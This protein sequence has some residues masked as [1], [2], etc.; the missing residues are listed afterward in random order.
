M[1]VV[2][3]SV[4][5]SIIVKDEFY[6]NAREFLVKYPSKNLVT[7]DLA[8]AET[9]NT[10]WKHVFVY[11]RIPLEKYNELKSLVKPLIDKSV[12]KVYRSDT[13]L[14]KALDRALEYGITVYDGLYVALALKLGYK[15][16]SFDEKLENKLA[17]SD[18][19]IIVKPGIDV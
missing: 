6:E 2:D 11:K 9:A 10:L 4:F 1:F 7:V 16:A 18:L 17:M 8:Y 3:A 19:N 12:S 14:V 13:I 5:S 15:L